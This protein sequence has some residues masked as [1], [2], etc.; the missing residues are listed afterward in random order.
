MVSSSSPRD[1]HAIPTTY[2][3]VQMRSR[4]EAR[5]AAFFDQLKWPWVY[6]PFDGAGYIPDFLLNFDH[7]K[8]VV[9]IKPFDRD[10]LGQRM[11]E[12]PFR[13]DNLPTPTCCV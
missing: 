5:W 11:T 9:D 6:E 1:I 2:K 12:L 10:G 3:G 13:F 8:F 7:R 4:L